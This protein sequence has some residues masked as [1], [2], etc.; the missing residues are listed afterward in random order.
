MRN[1]D[2]NS[3]VRILPADGS[4]P[5]DPSAP[6]E[7][8]Q[9]RWF[10]PILAVIAVVAVF[11]LATRPN[12][13]DPSTETAPPVPIAAIDA[14]LLDLRSEAKVMTTREW[15]QIDLEQ[16][17]T[18]TDVLRTGASFVAVGF[19]PDQ[20]RVWTSGTGS[21]WR[22][23]G[24]VGLPE[25]AR[26]SIDQV[27]LWDGNI[28]ALGSVDD[29]VGLWTAEFVST[30]LYA[31]RIDAM[32]SA[33]IAD[34]IAGPKLLAVARD[35]MGIQGWTSGDGLTW[36]SVGRLAQLDGHFIHGFAA[37]E[38]EFLAFGGGECGQESCPAVI[39]RS[40][41]GIDWEP[42]AVEQGDMG[43]FVT[44]VDTSGGNLVAVGWD[45]SDL[46][47]DIAV[48][49]SQDGAVWARVGSELDVL[50]ADHVTV[51]ATDMRS[52]GNPW[53]ELTFDGRSVEGTVGTVVDTDAGEVRISRVDEQAVTLNDA[54]T[55]SRGEVMGVDAEALALGVR[56]EGPRILVHGRVNWFNDTRL[57]VWASHDGGES[58]SRRILDTPGDLGSEAM[59]VG[60]NILLFDDTPDGPTVWRSTWNTR[61]VAEAATETVRSF[62]TAL[63]EYDTA[64][65][66]SLLP[67][68][69]DGFAPPQFVIPSLGN[70]LQEWWDD[71]TG[72][73]D[74]AAVADTLGYLEATQARIGIGDCASGVSLGSIDR[75]NV[76]CDVIVDSA[77]LSLFGFD[78]EA[79]DALGL[80]RDGQLAALELEDLPSASMWRVLEPHVDTEQGFTAAMAGDHLAAA[81][82]YLGT[83]LRPGATR[84]V[85]TEFGTMEWTWLDEPLVDVDYLGPVIWSDLGFIA[86]G[87]D[88]SGSEP[89]VSVW[90]SFDGREWGQIPAPDGAMGIWRLQPFA[91]GVVGESWL[92]D[93]LRLVHYDGAE[94]SEVELEIPHP[95]H[96]DTVSLA[97]SGDR[98]MVVTSSWSE[99]DGSRSVQAAV[100]GPDFSPRPVNL[101]PRNSWEETNI[102]VAGSDDGFLL[103]A[104]SWHGVRTNL[105]IWHTTNGADW[106]LLAESQALDDAQYVWNLQEHRSR[107]F[108]VGDTA[109]LR[110]SADDEESWC[111]N[112][113]GLWSSPDG[114]D[115]DRAFTEDGEPVAARA[116]GSGPLGLVAV[117]QEGYETTIPRE[118][119]ASID[120]SSWSRMGGLSLLNSDAEWWWI[121]APA[122]GADS[123]VMV[124]TDFGGTALNPN[125]TIIIVGHLLDN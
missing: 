21:T 40:D 106:R 59:T 10:L 16:D 60:A 74:P 23:A 17:A 30:W 73:L 62:L 111:M 7:P 99:S 83:I 2:A 94:W 121:D 87:R 92:G 105:N 58:W 103:T 115:W 41:D 77:L 43:A 33:R 51:G 53:V 24:R 11:F 39:Y 8:H 44:D 57:A 9:R 49:T 100:L 123:I 28:V 67:P 1:G 63:A 96:L 42:A 124:G 125:E 116:V 108:V 52:G 97:V 35:E 22:E 118:V 4:A 19:T 112:L 18:I 37:N 86:V 65:V 64:T 91:G 102:E 114:V 3:A 93:G 69:D 29:G 26:T 66:L 31:G 61:L 54:L 50:G 76:R 71:D 25:N 38:N 79:G 45:R 32:G 117:G 122:V 72:Q 107:Y 48:W 98:M 47:Q 110:C 81:E 89:T 109:E 55:L 14:E 82:R 46:R 113:M 80:L 104:S 56:T 90:Q 85:S 75:V 34:L 12:Q 6:P 13:P 101:P 95:E 120:G 78:G 84:T 68:T 119:Y 70:R 15:D 27:A 88:E 20:A 5:V 36:D